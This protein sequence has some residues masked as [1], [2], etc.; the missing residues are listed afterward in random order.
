M[1]EFP[2][3]FAAVGFVDSNH[4]EDD[5]VENELHVGVYVNPSSPLSTGR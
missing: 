1:K 2:M 5:G 4:D 3:R